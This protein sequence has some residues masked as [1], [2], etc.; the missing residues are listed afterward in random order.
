MSAVCAK[1]QGIFE[2]DF[3]H[4]APARHEIETHIQYLQDAISAGESGGVY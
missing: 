1:G 4:L 3:A 2:R